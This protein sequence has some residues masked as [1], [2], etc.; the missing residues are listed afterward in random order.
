MNKIVIVG[1]TS[2]I[3]FEL[4]KIFINKGWRVG[5][6]GRREQLLSSF[7]EQYPHQVE[8][9]VIDITQDDAPVKLQQLIDKLGGMDIYFHSI[10]SFNWRK[11]PCNVCFFKSANIFEKW[12]RY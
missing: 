2:G 3:G 11:Y 9:E 1:A 12:Y 8:Y 4:T 10:I 7:K 5:I 6:A